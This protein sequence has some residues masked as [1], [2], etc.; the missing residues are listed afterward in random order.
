MIHCDLIVPGM[1]YNVFGETLNLAQSQSYV[2][3]AELAQV[4]V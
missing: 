3:L 2:H 4:I 1:T